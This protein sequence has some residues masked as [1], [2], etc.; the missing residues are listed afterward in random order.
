MHPCMAEEL[1]KNKK[2]VDGWSADHVKDLQFGGKWFGPLKMLDSTVN[3][4][5]GRQMSQGPKVVTK[6]DTKRGAAIP[7]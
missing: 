1:K 7:E 5:L 2:A 6:F 4:S 3:S